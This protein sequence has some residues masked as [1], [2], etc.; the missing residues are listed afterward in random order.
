MKTNELHIERSPDTPEVIY[1]DNDSTLSIRGRSLPEDAHAFY[2]AL[3]IWAESQ[4]EI[5]HERQLYIHFDLDYFNSS[6]GRYLLEFLATLERSLRPNTR[7]EIVWFTDKEDELM[8]EKGEEF[9]Q[10]I[11]LPFSIRFL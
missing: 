4:K 9:Q 11:E 1:T 6:S 5:Y 2:S 8:I 3:I 10:L 7:T